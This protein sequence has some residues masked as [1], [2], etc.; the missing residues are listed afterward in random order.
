MFIN[1][2]IIKKV[3]LYLIVWVIVAIGTN[4]AIAQTQ[5]NNKR[6]PTINPEQQ[7]VNNNLKEDIAWNLF[8]YSEVLAGNQ[9][10]WQYYAKL[11]EDI[12]QKEKNNPSFF[13]TD[14]NKAKQGSRLPLPYAEN[15]LYILKKSPQM[16]KKTILRTINGFF[17][18][19]KR[20]NDNKLF[21]QDEHWSTPTEFSTIGGDCEDFAIA[22]YYALRAVNFKPQELR[23]VIVEMFNHPV[24]HAFLVARVDNI[25]F[26]LDNNTKPANLIIPDTQLKNKYK[27]LWSFNEQNAW[28]HF[29]TNNKNAVTSPS[30]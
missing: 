15:W 24:R 29:K 19:Q 13:K 20:G 22:K 25:N 26:V 7:T 8:E 27:P 28:Q 5:S 9:P 17:N 11:W 18:R 6:Q 23:I 2:Y 30:Q 3:F 1:R 14:S 4:Q 10:E 21:Q 16:D 12:Q